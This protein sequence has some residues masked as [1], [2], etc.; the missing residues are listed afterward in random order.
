MNP[1]TA[2]PPNTKP[3]GRR[4]GRLQPIQT[5]PGATPPPPTLETGPPPTPPHPPP[6]PRPPAPPP[7]SPPPPPRPPA[8][9]PLLHPR[10]RP[11]AVRLHH[12]GGHVQQPLPQPGEQLH[13][14]Q[15][16]HDAQGRVLQHAA[17]GRLQVGAVDGEVH[18]RYEV[19]QVHDPDG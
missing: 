2:D 14:R 19:Q 4:A 16:R 8:L 17:Q 9:L 6:P 18:L 7:P 13:R 12:A 5:P 1:P 15:R 11:G 3:Q 10:G